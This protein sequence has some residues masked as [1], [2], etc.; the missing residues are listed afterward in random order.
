MIS[1]WSLVEFKR[2]KMKAL[3]KQIISTLLATS[4][5]Q[6]ATIFYLLSLIC[7]LYSIS[8]FA[9]T[10]WIYTPP[11]SSDNPYVGN[12]FRS[13]NVES[14]NGNMMRQAEIYSIHED[15]TLSVYYYVEGS[16]RPFKKRFGNYYIEGSLFI[17]AAHD[18]GGLDVYRNVWKDCKVSGSSMSCKDYHEQDIPFTLW[19]KRPDELDQKCCQ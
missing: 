5:K 17:L 4:N 14:E 10:A 12:W 11:T 6:R 15:Q 7:C 1:R 13:Y 19:T 3:V 16:K 9:E 8:V 2:R 18:K